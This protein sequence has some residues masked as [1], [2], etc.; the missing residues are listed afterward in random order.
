MGDNPFLGDR[1]GVRTPMQWSADRNAGFSRA[2]E[3]AVYLPPISDH[4]FGYEAVNVEQQRQLRSS[5]LNWMRWIIRVRRGHPAFGGGDIVFLRSE[6]DKLLVYLRRDETEVLLWVAN[7]CE[8]AQAAE[9]D[10][11]EWEGPV[12]INVFGGCRFPA[13]TSRPYLVMLPGHEFLWLK[14]ATEAEVS[15]TPCVLLDAS[16]RLDL[17][18]PDRPLPP[19]PR[20]RKVSRRS[21]TAPRREFGPTTK[22]P[23]RGRHR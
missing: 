2:D 19:R 9:I 4:R 6:N 23:P 8:T 15:D 18:A 10:L 21:G 22:S 11:S 12:P 1:D 14:L 7:L 5:L 17:P 16:D 20:E 3:V 13:I